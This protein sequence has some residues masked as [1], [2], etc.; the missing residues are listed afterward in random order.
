[1]KKKLKSWI[2]IGMVA[3]LTSCAPKDTQTIETSDNEL[4][5]D[6]QKEDSTSIIDQI[7]DE[8]NNANNTNSDNSVETDAGKAAN[9]NEGLQKYIDLNLVDKDGNPI[10]LSDFEGKFI[11]LNFFGVWCKYCMD[12]MP[13]LQEVYSEYGGDDF[14]IL[15]V[16]A[17]TTENIGKD[18]VKE[19]YEDGGYTMPMMMDLD[20]TALEIYPVSGFPTTYFINKDGYIIG[21][22][23]GAMT[24]DTLLSILETYNKD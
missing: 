7:I 14:V 23:P 2:L 6:T 10:N 20:G 12:E 18:G 19:W 21:A 8:S 9:S 5:S 15:L 22:I 17:T 4:N 3:V 1:M 16:N 11:A 13:D 24:K